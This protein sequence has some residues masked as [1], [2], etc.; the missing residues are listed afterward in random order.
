MRSLSLNSRRPS[1]AGQQDMTFT[2]LLQLHL[3]TEEGQIN[4]PDSLE[5]ADPN[6][7]TNSKPS[8]EESFKRKSFELGLR[9]R[10]C[11]RF[12]DN[13]NTNPTQPENQSK[14]T[15]NYNADKENVC[16]PNARIETRHFHRSSSGSF[17]LSGDRE[18]IQGFRP[19]RKKV[20]FSAKHSGV[21]LA[22]RK[23][24]R[25]LTPALNRNSNPFVLFEDAIAQ[26]DKNSLPVQEFCEQMA[27]KWKK[28]LVDVEAYANKHQI[29]LP[30]EI[31]AKRDL[32][33]SKGRLFANHKK[34][35]NFDKLV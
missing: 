33:I 8:L 19:Q 9:M 10:R 15:S 22:S 18:E 28:L 23:P 6:N 35:Q 21:Q 4:T 7:F 24:V 32:L 31:I 3:H 13:L 26:R 5:K 29:E 1:E 2:R 11:K 30:P 25:A 27:S 12:L 20:P 17:S 34:N 16:L 14:M